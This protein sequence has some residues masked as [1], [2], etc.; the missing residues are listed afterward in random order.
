[1]DSIFL[2]CISDWRPLIY[3]AIFVAMIIEGD[4]ALFITGFL[5]YQGVVGVGN[6]FF[7]AFFG[8]II[9]NVLWYQMGFRMHPPLSLF[10]KWMK[11]FPSMIDNHLLKRP[12]YSIFISKFIYGLHHIVLMRMG[13]LKMGIR[14]YIGYDIG[15]TAVWLFLVGGLGYISGSAFVSAKH[16]LRVS[17]LGLLA[18]LMI[19]LSVEFLVYKYSK[20][21]L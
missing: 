10:K 4:I 17:E 8:T 15:A 12:F 6:A 13:M 9:G 5:A 11:Y 19:F 14:R 18:G 7:V 16:Y 20:K 2:S 3:L 1:M 21:R